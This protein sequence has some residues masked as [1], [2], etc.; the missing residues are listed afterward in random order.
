MW[1]EICKVYL[2][3]RLFVLRMEVP[4]YSNFSIKDYRIDLLPKQNASFIFPTAIRDRCVEKEHIVKFAGE[5]MPTKLFRENLKSILRLFETT[6]RNHH[7]TRPKEQSVTSYEARAILQ[8]YE[9]MPTT[10]LDLSSNWR[11]SCCFSRNG[12]NESF[13]YVFGIPDFDKPITIDIQSGMAIVDLAR[14]CPPNALR[15]H[16]QNGFAI[17]PY[18]EPNLVHHPFLELNGRPPLEWD[19]SKRLVAKFRLT[20]KFWESEY[21]PTNSLKFFFPDEID[22]IFEFANSM[23]GLVGLEPARPF[24]SS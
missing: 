21:A 20:K 4:T 19:L 7:P 8:H 12:G 18:P 2:Q 14:V 24:E 13:F 5:R 16:F 17:T 6:L 15:P 3:N 22:P 1:D 23:R 9:V 10:M 11:V